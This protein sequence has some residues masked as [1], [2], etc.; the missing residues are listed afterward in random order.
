MVRPG[1]GLKLPTGTVPL[2]GDA[3][4]ASDVKRA[5][6][7]AD[8]VVHLVG[9]PKPSP[10]KA[11]QFRE[12]D[13]ASI[14]AMADA[15]TETEAQP[16]LVYLSVA[17]PAPV[18]R[19]YVEVRA[20]GEALVRE[21][22]IRA[23]FMRPWYVL[24]PGHRWPYL[25]VP[26]YAVLRRLPGTRE[27]AERLGLVTLEQMIRAMVNAVEHPPLESVRIVDVPAIRAARV[28]VDL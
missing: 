20:A 17:Q 21:R 15:I 11:R 1:S 19:A 18:M 16:H 10:A 23:T 3:L 6:V 8:T 5:L 12:V 4:K 13:L 24:G 28:D 14:Q 2:V 7:G 9:V 25:L 22:G 27:S 26:V